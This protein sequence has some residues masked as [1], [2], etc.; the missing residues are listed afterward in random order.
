MIAPCGLDC[1]LCVAALKKENPC[2]GCMGSDEYK[3]EFCSKLCKIKNCEN[4]TYKQYRFCSECP[5]YP[6]EMSKTTESRYMSEYVMRESPLTNL[7]DIQNSG[8]NEFL[9]KQ[10]E[11]WTCKKCDGI[12]CVHTGICSKCEE[13]YIAEDIEF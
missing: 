8:I 3:P 11:K 13:K 6:C 1:S 5:D 2:S 7:M 4:L 10:R 12:V 9:L